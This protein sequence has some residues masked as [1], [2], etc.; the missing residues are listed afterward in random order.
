MKLKTLKILTIFLISNLI[1][2][3][4]IKKAKLP[5]G[6]TFGYASN[7]NILQNSS[8]ILKKKQKFP[9]KT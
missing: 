3:I 9:T 8:V 5:E 7:E 4:A 1:S 6:T 2:S